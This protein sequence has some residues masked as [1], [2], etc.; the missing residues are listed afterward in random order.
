MNYK[1]RSGFTLIELLVVIGIIGLL[2]GLAG[3]NFQ[4]ARQR[5]RDVQRKTELH[6]IEKALEMYKN[7]QYPTLYPIYSGSLTSTSISGF[8]PTYMQT[9]PV[10]PTE[11][12]STGSWYDYNYES[13]NGRSYIL[14]ACL[15]NTGDPEA[16]GTNCPTASG[17]GK[18]YQIS[19]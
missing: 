18:I 10:D 2:T 19:K 17:P 6:N 1:N 11:K 14:Q 5:A 15:E 9:M 13:T 8:V 16:T 3:F 7:D 12:N 4:M